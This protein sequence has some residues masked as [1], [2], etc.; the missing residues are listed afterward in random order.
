MKTISPL[1]KCAAVLA[2]ASFGAAYSHAEKV[3][4]HTDSD[5]WQFYNDSALPFGVLVG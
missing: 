4:L 5:T 3:Y 1:V 2:L